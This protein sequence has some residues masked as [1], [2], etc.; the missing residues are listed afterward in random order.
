MADVLL[1][2]F[3]VGGSLPIF[4]DPFN[5]DA[6][7]GFVGGGQSLNEAAATS[8]AQ[9]PGAPADPQEA[10]APP[11]PPLP[12][13][14]LPEVLVE[15]PSIVGTILTG[16]GA[17]LFPQPTGPARYDEAPSPPGPP[18]PVDI[19]VEFA[20]PQLPPNWN[21]LANEPYTP[22]KKPIPWEDIFRLGT[23][24][25]RK[26]LHSDPVTPVE[27]P[28][29]EEFELSPPPVVTR[30][31][32]ELPTPNNWIYLDPFNEL[33]FV[34]D[35]GFGS[36]PAPFGAPGSDPAP[37]RPGVSPAPGGRVQPQPTVLPSPDLFGAPL[38]D[39]F[40]NPGGNSDFAPLVPARPSPSPRPPSVISPTRQ[41]DP[42]VTALDDPLAMFGPAPTKPDAETCTCA[43]KPKKKPK[44]K[45]SRTEC[46]KGTYT[47]HARG[48][49]YVRR[50]QVPCDAA[51]ARTKSA[52]KPK[53]KTPKWRDVLNDVFQLPT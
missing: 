18:P 7:P 46:W 50:E 10:F 2:E 11:P 15:A 17:L 25:A 48:I 29:L 4:S 28:L 9:Y 44:K 22:P 12:I 42:F 3:T 30:G 53:V 43:A 16:I 33:S 27:V 20:E 5:Q 38:P 49:S 41:P 14:L 32:V 24:L 6:P 37:G 21:D 19:P 47:Q 1:D 34:T 51:P 52:R 26:L 13:E 36:A 31:V 39:V 23:N 8:E 35:T 45:S 40:A